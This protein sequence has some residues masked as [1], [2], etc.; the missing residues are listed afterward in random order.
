MQRSP[1]TRGCPDQPWPS[2]FYA[3]DDTRPA[4]AMYL[5][6]SAPSGITRKLM[7]QTRIE[8]DQEDG[9]DQIETHD[10]PR[11][12][13]RKAQNPRV[14][15]GKGCLYVVT[16]QAR[17]LKDTF[18]HEGT[19][20]QSGHGRPQKRGNRSLGTALCVNPDQ[21]HGRDPYR[22]GCTDVIL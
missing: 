9:R 22:A 3:I 4:S 6:L 18:N 12:K 17:N 8:P 1:D 2:C 5:S 15:P 16:A 7:S 13:D 19:R 10:Q 14:I 11:V 21:S 20:V